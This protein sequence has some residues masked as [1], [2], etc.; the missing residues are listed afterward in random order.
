MQNGTM[1][2]RNIGPNRERKTKIGMKYGAFLD[3]TARTDAN[4]FIITT[5]GGAK[6]NP[7]IFLQDHMPNNMRIGRYPEAALTR[8]LRRQI[9]KRVD[10]HFMFLHYSGAVNGHF[11]S[12]Q[13]RIL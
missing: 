6:P 5:N 13:L 10:W 7:D 11:R 8:G 2:N 4:G 1:T 12:R 9:I 3:V